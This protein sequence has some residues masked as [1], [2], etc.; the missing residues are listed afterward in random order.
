MVLLAK[1]SMRY[2]GQ[3]YDTKSLDCRAISYLRY[4][5]APEKYHKNTIRE[6]SLIQH[7]TH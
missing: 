7:T 1:H 2:M 4:K 3:I 5:W 6:S